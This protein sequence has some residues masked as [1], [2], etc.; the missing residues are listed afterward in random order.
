MDNKL[1]LERYVFVSINPIDLIQINDSIKFFSMIPLISVLT[2][3]IRHK[4]VNRYDAILRSGEETSC[5][6]SFLPVSMVYWRE[7]VNN[8]H[9]S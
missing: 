3:T 4:C 6:M 7:K 2:R 1:Q 8:Y 9:T 5:A